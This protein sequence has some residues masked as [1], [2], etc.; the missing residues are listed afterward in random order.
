MR[1]FEG[2]GS[3]VENEI[4]VAVDLGAALK[5]KPGSVSLL[6]P[7]DEKSESGGEVWE[8]KGV[9]ESLFFGQHILEIRQ[10]FQV[11]AE[12]AGIEPVLKAVPAKVLGLVATVGR[13]QNLDP[14]L[15]PID[16]RI[17]PGI[18]EPS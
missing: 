7:L 10:P 2:L 13:K 3:R 14:R 16:H 11:V 15:L 12:V 1:T 17:P 5:H 18:G 6:L 8:R 9:V 4:G